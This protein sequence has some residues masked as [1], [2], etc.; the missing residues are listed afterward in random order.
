MHQPCI[1]INLVDEVI[2]EK[3]LEQVFWV[4]KNSMKDLFNTKILCNVPWYKLKHFNSNLC[5]EL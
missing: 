3:K 5:T 4:M 1:Q 2:L